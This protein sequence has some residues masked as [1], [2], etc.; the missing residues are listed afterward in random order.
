MM[1]NTLKFHISAFSR[2]YMYS[3]V[4]VVPPIDGKYTQVLQKSLLMKVPVL[5]CQCSASLW[6]CI[7]SGVT[8]CTPIESKYTQA[9]L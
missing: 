4:T 8:V 3:N 9:S 7:Y 1:V 5:K 2:R 6:W